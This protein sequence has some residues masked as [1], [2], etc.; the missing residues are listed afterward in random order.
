MTIFTDFFG[1]TSEDN[2]AARLAKAVFAVTHKKELL[3]RNALKT[4]KSFRP[5]SK[6]D[7]EGVFS[8][9]FEHTT[10]QKILANAYI[11]K[12]RL[13]SIGGIQN[14]TKHLEEMDLIEK[15]ETEGLWQLVD[16][17]FAQWLKRRAKEIL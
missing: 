1:I 9:S 16:P 8:L 13:G 11:Q 6:P 5:V 3:W 10:T 7:S 14:S 4:F 12:F 17:V 15:T 2:V